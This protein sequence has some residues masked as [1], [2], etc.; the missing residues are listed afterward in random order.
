MVVTIE[1]GLYFNDALIV[2]ALDNPMKSKYLNEQMISEYKGFGG[3]RIED[4]ILI[5]DDSYEIFSKDAPKEIIDI[6]HTMN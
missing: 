5:T 1:P 2:A 6:E 3:V 4:T